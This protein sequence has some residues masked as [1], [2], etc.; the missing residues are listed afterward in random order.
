MCSFGSFWKLHA[1]SQVSHGFAW[2]HIV[3]CP[4]TLV[5]YSE[6]VSQQMSCSP[7]SCPRPLWPCASR[8]PLRGC[9][10]DLNT[11]A[12]LALSGSWDNLKACS[13]GFPAS[14]R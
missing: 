7:M 12:K 2:F 11:H 9:S 1:P 6:T 5:P 3:G 8:F 4:L 10:E 13:L 14:D